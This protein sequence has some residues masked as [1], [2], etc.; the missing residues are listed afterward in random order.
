MADF[1][2]VVLVG[3]LTR[4]LEV[5][6]TPGG[7]SVADGGMAVNREYK[8]GD[9][10]KVKETCF[11]DFTVWDKGADIMSQYAGKGSQLLIEGRLHLDTWEAKDGGG[12][13][14]KLKVICEN[15][16]FLSGDSKEEVVDAGPE[17]DQAP[18]LG[19]DET[20]PF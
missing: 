17:P 11:V 19:S 14:S 10:E 18:D 3:R 12:K 15:F 5:R 4:D 7:T 13:R 8:K 6:K 9:S 2:K 20:V 16:Q 1:N